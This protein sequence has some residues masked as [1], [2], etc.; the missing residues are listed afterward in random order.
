M[1]IAVI[2]FTQPTDQQPTS[3]PDPERTVGQRS[4]NCRMI[5]HPRPQLSCRASRVPFGLTVRES[6]TGDVEC[7]D[8]PMDTVINFIVRHGTLVVFAAVLGE[9]LGLPV[10]AAIVLLATG[11]AIGTGQMSLA[12]VLAAAVIAALIGDFVWYEL[13]A[14][15][16][17]P[18]L[19]T[20]CRLSL[21]PDTCIRKTEDVYDR[22]GMAA[23]VFAKFVPGLSTVAPPLA[24]VVGIGRSRFLLLDLIGTIAWTSAYVSAGWIFR[25]EI[26]WL[27]NVISQTT[28][29]ALGAAL[30]I[31]LG[32]VA[33]K[34][35]AR[36]R[37]LRELRIARV[38]P[39][40]LHMLMQGTDAP[41]IV[42]MRGDAEWAQGAL[43]GALRFSMNELDTVVPA[44]AG[45]HHVVLY[46][47]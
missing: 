7:N 46:C 19:G 38:T 2:I 12:P 31:G 44:R 30:L 26:E 5:C 25:R 11:A 23:I 42:D 29:S 34:Y 6:R 40:E 33:F 39:G 14:R 1:R 27:A 41:L 32:F 43:P 8:C 24:G 16:G 35:A 18:V 13:G 45:S 47:S 37:L 9:Q 17:R 22:Y 21:E 20:L 3:G 4:L 10:P 36:R 15:K 28:R